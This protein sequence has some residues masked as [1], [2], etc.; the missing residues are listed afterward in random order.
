MCVCVLCQS[1]HC[2]HIPLFLQCLH[3]LCFLLCTHVC[4]GYV[5]GVLCQS[6]HGE[7]IPLFLQCLTQTLNLNPTPYTQTL[8]SCELTF[9][10]ATFPAR[11]HPLSFTQ[12]ASVRL[13]RLPPRTH[14]TCN[15]HVCYVIQYANEWGIRGR[16]GQDE[17]VYAD[18][19]ANR[20][21][22][23]K[24]R[25]V[26]TDSW[27]VRG[28]DLS[29]NKCNSCFF[30]WA[31][32]ESVMRAHPLVSAVLSLALLSSLPALCVCYVSGVLCQS[33][34]GEHIPLFLQCLTQTLNLNPT[35]YTQTLTSCELTFILATFPAR[36]H[37]ISFTQIA[38]VRPPEAPTTHS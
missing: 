8:T 30:L 23:E 27:G 12:I 24:N 22:G 13:P 1:L 38:S 35:P 16:G 19:W 3:L 25:G 2:K 6:L 7:H 17:S 36:L 18:G 14:S 26:H 33:V 4:V 31:I 37:P 11:L 34:H 28:K 29:F 9:I 21:R 15:T 10:L 32:V 20:G 5:S